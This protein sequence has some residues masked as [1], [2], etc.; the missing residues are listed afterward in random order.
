MD[1]A[2][3]N[4][5]TMDYFDLPGRQTIMTTEIG[6][7]V[8]GINRLRFD[9]DACTPVDPPAME[10]ALLLHFFMRPQIAEI[11]IDDRSPV[12]LDVHEGM[13]NILDFQ[14]R[15]GGTIFK[16]FDIIGFHLPFAAFEDLAPDYRGRF[17]RGTT[18]NDTDE[19]DDPVVRHLALALLPALT[20]PH[21]VNRL[22][23]DHVGWALVGHVG[24]EYGAFEEFAWHARGRLA[25]WQERRAKEMI[26]ANLAGDMPLADI[27]AACGL[28]VGYFARAFRQTS[29]M[30]P[31]KWLL[32]RRVEAAKRLLATTGLT[33]A[34]IAADCGFSDQ[35]HLTRV[36]T[37][38][39]GVSPGLWR[40]THERRPARA[41]DDPV[42][43][44]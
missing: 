33:I 34:A 36:F 11:S 31:H 1:Q 26:D 9:G 27:A 5:Q 30:A 4:N 2:D 12:P 29:G 13:I 16:P 25:R 39:T 40:R 43:H 14:H 10:E 41:S 21:Q 20:R 37:R 44:A 7:A 15:Y 6:R 23:V 28:S 3:V 38:A 17:L 35:S 8:V 18:A 19:I 32:H 42:G 22:L 24:R